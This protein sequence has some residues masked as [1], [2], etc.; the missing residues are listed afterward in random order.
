[1]SAVLSVKPKRKFLRLILIAAVCTALI[2][3]NTLFVSAAGGLQMSTGYPGRTVKPGDSPSFS[4]DFNN[5]SG[6]GQIAALSVVSIPDGWKGYFE[7]GGSQVDQV[8]IKSGENA[9]AV[10]F[11]LSVPAEAAEGTYDIVLKANAANGFAD[12]LKLSLHVNREETGSSSFTT[13]YPEQEGSSSTSFT[14]STTIVNNTPSEQSYSLAANAPTGWQVAFKP[15]GD[16][17]QIA[18]ITLDARKSRGINVTV[19]PPEDTPA[20][21]YSI[22]CTAISANETLSADLS[23]VITGTYK[24]SLST[25]SGRLSLDAN[26]NKETAVTLSIAN[27]GNVDLQNVNLS[28]SVPDSWT[29]RFEQPSIPVLTAGSTQ[30]ITAYVK[31]AKDAMSGDYVTSISAKTAE[32]SSTADFRVTVKTETV[33]GIVGILIIL[34]MAGGLVYVF[35]KYGRR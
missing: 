14:F 21:K 6:T 4:L 34:A 30:E 24:L 8:F 11:N 12:T 1:M 10:S 18:S 20:A 16:S 31:P 33:W 19:T 2:S 7:G 28:S 15:S 27:N 13:Q 5:S 9:S 17:T 23:V 25:P 35:R 26:A 29:V 32:A 22:P 3:M